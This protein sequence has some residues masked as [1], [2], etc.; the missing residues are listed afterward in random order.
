MLFNLSVDFPPFFPPH[1]QALL[2]ISFV[3][4]ACH[5]AIS[6]V[7]LALGLTDVLKGN[8]GKCAPIVRMIAPHADPSIL[9][10]A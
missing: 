1:F 7:I 5:V 2:L 9:I 4:P 6:K 3:L 8:H 10:E